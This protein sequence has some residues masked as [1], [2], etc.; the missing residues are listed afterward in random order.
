V[1]GLFICL[2]R[3][4]P[5]AVGVDD[6]VG[7]GHEADGFGEGDVIFGKG[8]RPFRS[9]SA[10]GSKMRQLRRGMN[11]RKARYEIELGKRLMKGKE[12]G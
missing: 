4:W 10:Q 5:A 3:T 6:L 11:C 1:K 12:E 2:K 8:E 9:W 7:R